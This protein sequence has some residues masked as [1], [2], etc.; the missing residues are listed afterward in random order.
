MV[1][2]KTE[3]RLGDPAKVGKFEPFLDPLADP[4]QDLDDGP[5]PDG[6]FFGT[7]EERCC[8]VPR[9]STEG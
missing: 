1:T 7:V 5:G 8:T 9:F 4:P 3:D 6:L 2:A